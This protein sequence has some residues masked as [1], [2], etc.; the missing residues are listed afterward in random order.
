MEGKLAFFELGGMHGGDPGATPASGAS[1][2]AA[3]TRALRSAST[4]RRDRPERPL[5]QNPGMPSVPGYVHTPG[6]HCGSTALRN[7]LAFHGIA[8]S[9]EMAL[10]LGAGAGFYYLSMEDSSPSRWF[11]GRTARLE[12]SFRELTGAALAMRTFDEDDEAWDAARAEVDAGHPSLLLTDIYHLDHYGNSAHFPGHAVILAGYDEEVAYLSDTGFEELQTTR[13]EHL[14]KARRSNHPAFPMEGHIF[15]VAETVD[16]ERLEAAVPAAIERATAEMLEP[17]FGEF[18]GLPALDRLAAEAG[19]W[20]EAVEDWQWCARFAYQVIERRGTGGGCF[21]RMYSRFL[22][23]AGRDEA[24]LAAAAAARWTELAGA[25]HAASESEQ[26]QAAL[27]S[28]VGER[29]TRVA[30]AEH[31]LWEALGGS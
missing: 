16:R 26:P 23:E 18:G 29:A 15:T 7:L 6:N 3:T 24:P 27:W 25:F 31:R 17:P 4:S 30:A 13:L 11:S 22:E 8:I 2:S 9:E 28:E 20:P 14:A 12:E 5:G 1:S 10:G 19:S 21:R